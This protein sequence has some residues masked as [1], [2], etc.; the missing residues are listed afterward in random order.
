MNTPPNMRTTSEHGKAVAYDL[1]YGGPNVYAPD[2][3]QVVDESKIIKD[4]DG[5][6][7]FGEGYYISKGHKSEREA[8]N[9]MAD[10]NLT[11]ESLKIE[12]VKTHFTSN[13]EE[14]KKN[15]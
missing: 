2:T 14:T 7:S 5:N 3:W 11:G 15:I 4:I 13:A 8:M 9:E 10:L 1:E 6:V 12:K